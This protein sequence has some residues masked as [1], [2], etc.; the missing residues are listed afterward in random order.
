MKG[1]HEIFFD[2]DRLCIEI[3][4]GTGVLKGFEIPKNKQD[5]LLYHSGQLIDINWQSVQMI[6]MKKHSIQAVESTCIPI[7]LETITSTLNSLLDGLILITL[8]QKNRSL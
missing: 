7:T 4:R 5:A 8:K 3:A 6:H 1:R 2:E